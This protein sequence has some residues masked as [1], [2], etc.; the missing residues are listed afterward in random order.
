MYLEVYCW[1]NLEE[2]PQRPWCW[3]SV[4][5]LSLVAKE[6]HRFKDTHT[7]GQQAT[8]NNKPTPN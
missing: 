3:C 1:L 6:A 2:Q 8:A 4:I 7:Q 5:M